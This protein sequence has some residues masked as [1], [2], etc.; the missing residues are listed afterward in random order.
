MNDK[1]FHLLV[2]AREGIIF[3]GDVDSVTSFNEAGKF[4]VLAHHANFISLIQKSLTI[5]E[6]D[7]KI[8]ELPVDTALLRTKENK[9]EVYLGIHGIKPA[10]FKFADEMKIGASKHH[11]D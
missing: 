7:G 3:E 1:V 5:I 4:D 11:N 9:V 8:T 2:R 6:P 10:E